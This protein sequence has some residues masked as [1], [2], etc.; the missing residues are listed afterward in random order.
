MMLEFGRLGW[1]ILIAKDAYYMKLQCIDQWGEF[2]NKFG[3]RSEKVNI[4]GLY[5][6]EFW[7]EVRFL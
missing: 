5:S 7:L 6:S 2:C 3:Q 4:T 1:D